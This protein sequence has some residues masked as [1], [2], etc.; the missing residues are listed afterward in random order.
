MSEQA[1]GTQVVW[2]DIPALDI[3]RAIRFYSAVLAQ[4][5]EK[6]EHPGFAMGVLPHEGQASGGCLAQGPGHTPSADGPLLYLDASGR[7]D[8]ALAAVEPNGGKILEP[9]HEIPPYGF[10]AI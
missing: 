7:L 10:R 9:K 1:S 2:F 4:A 3:D 6:H 5:I 8:E